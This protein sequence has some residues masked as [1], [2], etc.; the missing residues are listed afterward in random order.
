MILSDTLD[1]RRISR[2]FGS[3]TMLPRT[4]EEHLESIKQRRADKTRADLVD[5]MIRI[6][7]VK[8]VQILGLDDEA[9]LARGRSRSQFMKKSVPGANF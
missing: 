6:P 9:H 7:A 3:Q 4:S 8:S 5:W 2:R 1:R